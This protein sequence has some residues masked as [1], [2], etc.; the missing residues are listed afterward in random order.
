MITGQENISHAVQKRAKSLSIRLEYIESG[1]PQQNTYIERFNRTVRYEW[2]A[3]QLLDSIEEVQEFVT[4]W[5][6]NYNHER[7]HMVQYGITSYQRRA[8][9][10]SLVS[11]SDDC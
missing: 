4:Q 3:K 10:G 9:H 5:M 7:P 2:Q 1:K 11:T 8:I 6:W